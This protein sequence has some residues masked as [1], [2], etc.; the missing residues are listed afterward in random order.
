MSEYS[1]LSR[2]VPSSASMN[3]HIR[4]EACILKYRHLK[5]R[6][7]ELRNEP[8]SQMKAINVV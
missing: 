6:V 8:D 4:Q 2:S 5:F 7:R 1:A 3:D